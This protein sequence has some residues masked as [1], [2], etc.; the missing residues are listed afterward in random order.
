MNVF[1]GVRAA[2]Q[3]NESLVQTF[4]N[5]LCAIESLISLTK[6]KGNESIIKRL[7]RYTLTLDGVLH[8]LIESKKLNMESFTDNRSKLAGEHG[9]IV[10]CCWCRLSAN[11]FFLTLQIQ[12]VEL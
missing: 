9:R 10:I 3:A 7:I 5:K 11:F 12:I 1:S 2:V 4:P 6:D 8:L